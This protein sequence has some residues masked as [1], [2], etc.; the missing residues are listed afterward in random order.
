[1]ST[2]RDKA[3]IRKQNKMPSLHHRKPK[4]IGGARHDPANQSWLP[5]NK[6]RAWHTLFSNHSAQSIAY[7]INDKYL[8]PEYVFICVRKEA[9]CTDSS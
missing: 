3:E 5:E 6:H 2:R 7:M 4:S 1:M 8:D 9:V